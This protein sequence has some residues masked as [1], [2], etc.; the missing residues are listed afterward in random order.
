MTSTQ[1]QQDNIALIRRGFEAF[2]AGDMA[3]LAEIFAPDVHW[4]SAP[5]GVLP[6]D[7]TDRDA[8]FAMFGQLQQETNGTFRSV[9]SSYAANDDTV[10]VRAIASGSRRGRSLEVDEIVMF[11]IAGGKV[12]EARLY[13]A[14]HEKNVAFWS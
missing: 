10:F 11:S 6:G 13:V 3:T 8:L 12:R 5:A 4:F 2:G 9:P 1:V 7:R 14:D